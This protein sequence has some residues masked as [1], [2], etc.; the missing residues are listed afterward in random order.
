M[1]HILKN[2][3]AGKKLSSARH[4]QPGPRKRGVHLGVECLEDRTLLSG[5]GGNNL[6]LINNVSYSQSAQESVSSNGQYVV[7][8]S[9]ADNLVPGFPVAQGIEAV[10]RRDLVNGTTDLVSANLAGKADPFSAA[11][12]AVMTPD[13]RYVAFSYNPDGGPSDL[14]SNQTGGGVFVRDMQQQQTYLVS[15]GNTGLYN[16]SIAEAASGKLVIAYQTGTFGTPGDQVYVTTLNLDASGAIQYGSLATR[17]AS[18]DNTGTGTGANGV[19]DFAVVSKDGSTVAFASNASNLPGETKDAPKGQQQYQLF[20]YNV[21]SGTVTQISPAPLAGDSANVGSYYVGGGTLGAFSVS[22]NGQFI[23]YVESLAQANGSSLGSELLVWNRATGKNTILAHPSYALYDPVISGD[24]STVAYYDVYERL[25]AESNWQATPTTRQLLPP[26]GYRGAFVP[27]LSD[28]GQ[29]IAYESQDPS[30]HYD[31]FVYNWKT[32]VTQ[33]AGTAAFGQDYFNPVAVSAD[34]KTVAFT[35]SATNLVPGMTGGPVYDNVFAYSVGSNSF[36]L[37]S[38]NDTVPTFTSPSSAIFV[39]NQPNTF[40]VTTSSYFPSTISHGSL[41][42]WITSFTDNG[43]G[44]ATITGTPTAHGT[45]AISLTVSNSAGGTAS[46]TLTINMDQAPT[47]KSTSGSQ[48][49][50]VGKSS[51]FSVAFTA[52]SPTATTFSVTGLPKGLSFTVSGTTV[53]IVGV[54][55]A[56]TGGKYP[57]TITATN[58]PATQLTVSYTLTVNQTP[59]FT[60]VASSTF[61]AGQSNSFTIATSGFPVAALTESGALPAGVT[62]VDNGNGTA[63]LSGMPSAKGRYLLTIKATSGAMVASQSFTLTTVS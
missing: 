22:Y 49:F 35:S 19:S 10:F 45:V 13:G 5:V 20:A 60:S 50:T 42:A 32:G 40:T 17:L 43:N 33:H 25:F 6:S 21:A 31:L 46:Q 52:G 16:P 48:T 63:T 29:V 4:H 59:A 37:V 55:A 54:P 14:T 57:I 23:A 44:T 26:S 8:T 3:F 56:G 18:A 11:Y 28:N 15:L 58:S 53:T 38:A 34:G 51:S 24:G 41:P 12:D 30:Y 36:T 61:T 62:F 9:N 7:F 47:F 27:A 1:F 39:V 2:W